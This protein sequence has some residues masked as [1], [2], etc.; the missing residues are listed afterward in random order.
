MGLNVLNLYNSISAKTK[1]YLMILSLVSSLNLG[2]MYPCKHF[3]M[4]EIT[5]KHVLDS[6]KFVASNQ[7]CTCNVKCFLYS[8]NPY[9]LLLY[10]NISIAIFLES[11]RG[12]ENYDETGT[13]GDRSQVYFK[14][15]N[16]L[17]LLTHSTLL[18]FYLCFDK[19]DHLSSKRGSLLR[20]L[21]VQA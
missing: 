3:Y 14:H 21:R 5:C 12:E 8:L 7:C 4:F 11:Q 10:Q 17:P 9:F 1:S 13:H 16:S 18:C 19:S 15:T 20:L 6:V 2:Y